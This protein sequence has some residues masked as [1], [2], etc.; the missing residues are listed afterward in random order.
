MA[1]RFSTGFRNE[2]L[3]AGGK[4]YADALANG[5]IEIYSGTQPA[6]ADDTEVGSG[7]LLL[8]V[9]LNSGAF[10][11]GSPTNG[12]NLDAAV[13]GVLS[14]AAAEVWSGVGVADGVAGW[15]RFYDN[16]MVK[17]ASTTAIRIDGAIATSGAEI[18][19]AN[20]TITTAGTSTLDTFN[21]TA[22]AA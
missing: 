9:T 5:V 19:M 4:S 15:F 10:T 12:L 13:D 17:G 22:P 20:T 14:K 2:F 3:K 16:S 6:S 18:V 7:T 11:P 8:T 1:E 21:I